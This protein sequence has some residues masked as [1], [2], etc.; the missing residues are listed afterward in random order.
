MRQA[1]K[2]SAKYNRI[3]EPPADNSSRAVQLKTIT[4]ARLLAW[5]CCRQTCKSS[6]PP[7][8]RDGRRRASY[9]DSNDAE[10]RSINKVCL[11]HDKIRSHCEDRKSWQH[12]WHSC[13]E[14]GSENWPPVVA[15]GC[16]TVAHPLDNHNPPPLQAQ[17]RNVIDSLWCAITCSV[18]GQA[19]VAEAHRLKSRARRTAELIRFYVA[20]WY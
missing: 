12:C 6:A 3:F 13:R 5:H 9:C 17:I 8:E 16:T 11:L 19:D 10:G 18:V 1:Q 7:A 20:V 15:V 14:S 4:P 2:C